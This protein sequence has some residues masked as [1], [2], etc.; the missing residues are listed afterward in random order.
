MAKNG[1]DILKYDIF[2]KYAILPCFPI[3]LKKNG[4]NKK[5]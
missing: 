3:Y 4:K 1:D 5:F 2:E